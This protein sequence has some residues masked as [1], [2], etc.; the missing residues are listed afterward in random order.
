M[1]RSRSLSRSSAAALLAGL[2]AF[3]PCLAGAESPPPDAASGA[4]PGALAGAGETVLGSAL[5]VVAEAA[6]I[7]SEALVVDAAEEPIVLAALVGGAAILAIA[8]AVL[9]EAPGEADAAAP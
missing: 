3:A 1:S 8:A 2:L 9:P 5:T 7:L 6:C 4:E